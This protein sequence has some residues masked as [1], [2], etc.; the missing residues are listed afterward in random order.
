MFKILFLSVFIVF[1]TCQTSDKP[2]LKLNYI[3]NGKISP[4]SIFNEE[5]LLKNVNGFIFHLDQR[6]QLLVTTKTV[7]AVKESS[8]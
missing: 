2:I 3:N 8:E 5:E 7:N 6:I 4:V 1:M